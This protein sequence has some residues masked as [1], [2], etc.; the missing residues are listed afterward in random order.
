MWTSLIGN[1]PKATRILVLH[2]RDGALH[3]LA[4]YIE[5]QILEDRLVMKKTIGLLSI[6]AIGAMLALSA[7]AN[8]VRLQLDELQD[9]CSLES[10][11]ALYKDFLANYKG[12]TAKAYEDAKKYVACP[13]DASDESETKRIDYLKNWIGKYEKENRKTRF[14]Q[15][16]ND[17]KYAEAIPLGK[18]IVNDEPEN[19]GILLNIANA[20]YAAQAT[21]NN[22]SFNNDAIAEAKKSLQLIESG[23]AVEKWTPFESKDDAVGW[24][25]YIIATMTK[26]KSPAE[27]IPYFIKSASVEGTIKKLPYTYNF[28]G[29]AYETGPY[30]KQSADY[31]AK[32]E[33]KDET[34]ESKLALENINQLV[35]RMVDAYARAVATSGS[36]SKYAGIKADA[37]KAATDW[38]K[39]RHNNSETGLNEMIAGVLAKP[40]PPEPT[41]LTSLPTPTISTPATGTPT[42]GSAPAGSNG[43]APTGTQPKPGTVKPAPTPTPTPVKKPPLHKAHAGN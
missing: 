8:T 16:I 25:N 14:A 35:D 32:Y 37:L 24:L 21:G 10:K 1:G 20:G 40:L 42:T 41:P 36:D 22:S 31:K 26:D 11:T 9:P 18:D 30:A 19:L 27:S 4:E 33:N 28:L 12:D 3:S 39:F 34:P 5:R 15:L 23:K 43:L 7:F 17:K 2:R 6:C 13:V 38:Y 29:A